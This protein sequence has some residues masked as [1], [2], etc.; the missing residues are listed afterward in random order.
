MLAISETPR[1][2]RASLARGGHLSLAL[3]VE[4]KQP[5]SLGH[6]E[7]AACLLRGL[8]LARDLEGVLVVGGVDFREPLLV[9]PLEELCVEGL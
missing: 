8:P 4:L 6:Y 5:L 1:S 9:D 3:S 7:E 2:R